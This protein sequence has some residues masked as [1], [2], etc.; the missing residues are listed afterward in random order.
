[1]LGLKPP[2]L[3]LILLLVLF[4]FGGKKLPE[5][6]ASIGDAIRGFKKAVKDDPVAKAAPSASP[7]AVTAL[8]DDDR[9]PRALLPA[10]KDASRV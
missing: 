10:S 2:E 5:L 3:I 1:M 7:E 9:S 4:L 6:G 8:P